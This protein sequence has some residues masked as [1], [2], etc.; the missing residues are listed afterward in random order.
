MNAG[1]LTIKELT[2]A[3]GGGITPRMVRHYHQLGLIPQPVRSPSNYRLYTKKD[4]L[5]LQ[6]I[7]A[8]KQQGF[9]LNH[10]RHILEVEPETD[11]TTNM[12]GQLQQQYRAVIQQISQLRQTASALEGLLGRDRHCQIMQAEVLAQLKLLDVETQAGLGGLEQLWSGLDAEVHTHSEAF[13]ESLQ[14]LLPDL[15]NR[16]EIEQHLISQLVL[17]CGDVSLVSFV[18]LSR[19]AIAASRKALKSGCQVVVDVPTVAAALDQTRLVHLG[20]QIETLIDNPHVTTVTEAELAFW[21]HQEWREKL[22]QV[23]NGCVL[24][25]GYAPSVLLEASQ[26]IAN[27]KIQPALVIGMPI[28][29]SH[30]PAAKRQLTQNEVPFVTIEGT[31]GGG[32]LAA[33]ALNALVESLIEKPDCHCYTK[34]AAIPLG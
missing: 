25:I 3:V 11:T 18:K 32:A 15:S 24:V 33:T 12:I 2:D 22:Q 10:I 29:F 14:R 28:G 26:A 31:L 23:T 13:P 30:A 4:V 19:D 34:D 21:Q 6:R 17:A 8:L 27:Q 1:C 9:Q 20:C 16:S 7:V 5:R